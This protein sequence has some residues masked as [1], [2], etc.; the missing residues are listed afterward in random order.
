MRWKIVF[1]SPLDL[2]VLW[3]ASSGPRKVPDGDC[4]LGTDVTRSLSA[5]GLFVCATSMSANALPP[6]APL[7]AVTRIDATFP[8]VRYIHV[9]I[10]PGTPLTPTFGR[11]PAV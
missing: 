1:A 5:N 2:I 6:D 10:A 11:R 4:A 7:S 8:I 9:P 3:F